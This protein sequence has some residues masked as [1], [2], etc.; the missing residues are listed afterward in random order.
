MDES[1]YEQ[2]EELVEENDISIDDCEIL[3]FEEEVE[4]NM[5]NIYHIFKRT[6]L[7]LFENM[8]LFKGK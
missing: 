8:K 3:E 5:I 6:N 1:E 4:E 2:F 7:D